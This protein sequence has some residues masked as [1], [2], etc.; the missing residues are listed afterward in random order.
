MSADLA[1][2][3]GGGV[4]LVLS[5][6]GDGLPRVLHWGAELHGSLDALPVLLAPPRAHSALDHP[7]FP[8]LVPEYSAGFAGRPGLEVMRA[9]R[10]VSWSPALREADVHLHGDG[11]ATV[12]ASDPDLGLELR[13]ELVLAESGLLGVRHTVT[14]TAAEALWVLA[15][16]SALPVPP[17]AVEVLDLTGRS[18]RERSPQRRP[19]HD[20]AVARESRRGRT[21]HDASL[22]MAAGTGGFGFETGEVW[23]VH[24]AWSGDHLTYAE[25]LPEG[26]AVIGGGELLG[27]GEIALEPGESYTSPQVLASWSDSG[28]NAVAAR[29]HEWMRTRP[30]HPAAPRPVVLNTWEA[31]YFNHD[32]TTLRQLA[33][34]AAAIGVERFVLDDG[35]FR[36]RRDDLRALGDWSVDADLW[37]SGLHPLADYVRDLG[38]EFGLW[39]EPEMINPDSD[40]ARSHPDWVLRGRHELPAPWRHQQV[41]DLAQPEAYEHVR[42]ALFALLDEYDIAFLKWDH[43]RDLIDVAHRG[44]PAVHGQTLAFYRLLDEL[45]DAYP[46]LEIESCASGGARVDLEVLQRTQRVWGSD[47]NDPLERVMIQRWTGVLV[48]PELIGS[49]VSGPTSHTTGRTQTLSFRAVTALFGHF[50]IEWDLT[51]I[52]ETE[53]DELA[54]WIEIYK[55]HRALLH[56]GRV[57]VAD[58]PD[59]AMSVH[60]VVAPDR[61]AALY[62]VTALTTSKR[63]VPAPVRLP[64]LDP[65]RTY[66][67]ER[68][69]PAP[70]YGSISAGWLGDGHVE[71]S[72]LLLSRVG[73]ALPVLRPETALL[74]RAVV[75]SES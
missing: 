66:R 14:N 61:S 43:N 44:R 4:S 13:S 64:G 52:S 45:H 41:L 56:N 69:G 23:A 50:G 67:L 17:R 3:R 46:R 2:L 15:L 53:R 60:G 25:R 10:G 40:L 24:V 65:V 55:E 54:E 62:A 29:W 58:E 28:L 33:A 70:S 47:C 22:I 30:S 20:G 51:R 37:P 34:S 63:A 72:G 9:G 21:G 27:P 26:H 49:H 8:G 38:M 68:L 35:W 5:T 18:F 7:V 6:R 36:G 19:F 39:V 59:P 31:V 32:L 16:N 73:A 11:S 12:T 48:P 1:H 74:L 75:V 42:D 57:V 71:A